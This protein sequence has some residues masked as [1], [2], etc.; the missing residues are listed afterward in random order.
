VARFAGLRSV[1]AVGVGAA[2][3][4]TVNVTVLEAPPNVAV[5]VDEAVALTALVVT[6]KFALVAP[7]GTVTLEGT[8]VAVEFSDSEI[9]APPLGAAALK[10]IVPV[11][12]FPPTTLAG[13]TATDDRDG[14]VGACCTVTAVERNPASICALIVTV[15]VCVGNV[16]M[17]NVA[18]VAP[19]GI[20]TLSGT[21]A[22]SGSPLLRFTATPAAGAGPPSLTVPVADW[23]ATTVAGVTLIDVR[24]GRLG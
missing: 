10:V 12:A 15:V 6:V 8:V 5:I 16:V 2:A 23:P 22:L 1:G 18:L 9:T 19:D 20:V 21:C 7:A 13:L 3:G 14:P 4:F 24:G 17:G 11:E